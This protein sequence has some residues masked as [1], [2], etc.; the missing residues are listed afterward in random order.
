MFV[1]VGVLRVGAAKHAEAK[2]VTRIIAKLVWAKDLR[3]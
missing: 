3:K 2:I 1:V